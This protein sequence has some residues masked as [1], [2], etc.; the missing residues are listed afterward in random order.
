MEANSNAGRMGRTERRRLTYA[1]LWVLGTVAFV[2]L[3]FVGLTVGGYPALGTVAFF[4]LGAAAVAL[5][6][7]SESILFDERD[8]E[9]LETASMNT[10]QVLSYGSAIVFPIVSALAGLG[11]VSFPLWLAPIGLFVAGLFLV[12]F[13]FL[14][15][16]RRG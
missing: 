12:W 13:G 8:A 5:H 7:A 15:L 10:I 16:A 14:V 1:G 11:Y 6:G 2:G 3:A 9:I 4:A